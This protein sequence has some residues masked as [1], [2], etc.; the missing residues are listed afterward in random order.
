M[1]LEYNKFGH[2]EH[3]FKEKIGRFGIQT[4]PL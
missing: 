3:I 1:K 2:N 4:N